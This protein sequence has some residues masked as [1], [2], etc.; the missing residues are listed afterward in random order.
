MMGQF[1]NV[2]VKRPTVIC[3][4]CSSLSGNTWWMS[5]YLDNR[6]NYKGHPDEYFA[7]EIMELFR[8][9]PAITPSRTSRKWR[10]AFNG[11][12]P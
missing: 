4:I 12:E 5:I 3:A 6:H 9:E 10:G 11:L 8:S 7:R 1:C 2:F